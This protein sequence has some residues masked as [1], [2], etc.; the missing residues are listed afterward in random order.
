MRLSFARHQNTEDARTRTLVTPDGVSLPIVVGSR[1][2]RLG[3]MLIDL[4]FITLGF[5]ILTI[6]LGLLGVSLFVVGGQTD[7]V[8]AAAQGLIIIFILLAFLARY[9][10]FLFFELGPRGATPGKRVVGL[11]VA[12]RDGGRLTAQMVLARNL[13]RDAELF[14]PLFFYLGGGQNDGVAGAALMVWLA[15]FALFPLFNRDVLRAGDLVAGTWVVEAPSGKL[16][17][18]MSTAPDRSAHYRF[19]PEELSVYGER[20]L[21]VLESVLR[22]DRP[23]A[24]QEVAEAIT[25]KI[26]WQLGRGD[27]REFLEAFYAALRGHLESDLRFGKRKKDKFS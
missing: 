22:Q 19:G 12:A 23:E 3:A 18:A 26:G 20:E 21:Q 4:T 16:E 25:R 24:L 27:Q 7:G 9:G 2:A 5:I 11:R 1:G 6:V 15:V 10:Y 17:D 14:V 13:M 8:P